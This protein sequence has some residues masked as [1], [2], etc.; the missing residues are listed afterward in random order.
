MDE[1]D[2]S[3]FKTLITDLTA[4]KNQRIERLK[5]TKENIVVQLCETRINHNESFLADLNSLTND[6]LHIHYLAEEQNKLF[7]CDLNVF[8]MLGLGETMHSY[9]LAN[10]LNPNAAHGQKH[11]FINAFLDL[12]NIK[13]FGSQENWMVTAEKGRIDILLKRNHPHSVVVIEN[14]SNYAIDQENQLYRY[15]HNEIYNTIRK[16]H[17]PSDYILNPPDQYYQLIYLSPS[18]WKIPSNNSLKKPKNWANDLP[19]EVPLKTRHLLFGEFIVRWLT[20]SLEQ[21]PN[22][23]QRL[24][25]HIKQYVELWT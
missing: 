6:F 18:H 17:L 23:N 9:I 15:W 5:C 16:R 3:I 8:K 20:L 22:Q 2:I 7:S 4:F 12:L 13:R 25:E 24:K 1:I 14:K 11:L 21:I 19:D 10:F